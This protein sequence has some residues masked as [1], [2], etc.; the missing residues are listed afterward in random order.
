M[1]FRSKG[2]KFLF[3]LT[4]LV[5]I[6]A[7]CGKDNAEN[8]ELEFGGIGVPDPAKSH[9][10]ATIELS[11]GKQIVMELYPEIARIP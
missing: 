2:F 6:L 5:V 8:D 4:A 11:N 1:L 7:G 9:P 10:V 3:L